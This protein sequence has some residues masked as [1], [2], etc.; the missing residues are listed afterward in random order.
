MSL[1]NSRAGES[2]K[3]EGASAVCCYM[4]KVEQLFVSTCSRSQQLFVV[5]CPRSQQQLYD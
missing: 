5:T 2:T 1:S 4:P 3:E